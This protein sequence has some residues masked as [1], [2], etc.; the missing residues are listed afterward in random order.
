MEANKRVLEKYYGNPDAYVI[1]PMWNVP[2]LLLATAVFIYACNVFSRDKRKGICGKSDC[3]SSCCWWLACA[4]ECL[5]SREGGDDEIIDAQLELWNGTNR[6]TA[7]GN[8]LA[9]NHHDRST[10]YYKEPG[11]DV[12]ITRDSKCSTHL[13][14]VN[15]IAAG[16]GSFPSRMEEILKKKNSVD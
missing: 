3:S 2:Y 10:L 16:M 7:I 11:W 8:F 12:G 15:W 5:K 14:G 13:F 1:P 9:Y 4:C 6:K